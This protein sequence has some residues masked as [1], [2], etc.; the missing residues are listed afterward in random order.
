MSNWQYV[1]VP[2]WFSKPQSWVPV[3]IW[4]SFIGLLNHSHTWK[5]LTVLD[6]LIK[7]QLWVPHN[8]TGTLHHNYKYLLLRYT[9]PL[10]EGSSY[11]TSGV[12]SAGCGVTRKLDRAVPLVTEPPCANFAWFQSPTGGHLPSIYKLFGYSKVCHVC[13]PQILEEK[14]YQL[15]TH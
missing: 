1:T 9:Y 10:P 15:F 8:L 13:V 2:E 4:M 3:C 12:F 14:P 11:V 7:P 5:Y 6:W